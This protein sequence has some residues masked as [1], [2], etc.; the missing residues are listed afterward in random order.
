MQDQ[1]E[2]L[3][4]EL[5]ISLQPDPNSVSDA[6]QLLDVGEGFSS[7]S[8]YQPND[9]LPSVEA[10]LAVAARQVPGWSVQIKGTVNEHHG[11][12]RCMIRRS[13]SSDDD[14]FLGT[15]RGP[16]MSQALFAALLRLAGYLRDQQ[17][18]Q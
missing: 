3:A 14:E 10:L 5:E 7:L 18:K 9:D 6:S 2:R 1:F 13:S 8:A 4:K 17:S 12:W 11:H 16:R 15:G